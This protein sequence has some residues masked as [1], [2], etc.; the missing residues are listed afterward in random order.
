[1]QTFLPYESYTKSAKV[2][3]NKRLGKQRVETLQI[4][5]TLTGISD[6]W[7]NHPAVKMWKGYEVSL[8]EYGLAVC[9]EWTL[10]G[11]N[12]SCFDKIMDVYDYHLDGKDSSY[13]WWL[14]SKIH[15]SHQSNLLKKFPAHYRPYFPDVDPDIPYYWPEGKSWPDGKS[16]LRGLTL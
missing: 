15:E 14:G 10:R 9:Q 13:P 3:D 2:L 16:L 1:M 5:N 6:G 7:K 4:L 12:D 8:V 11:Y